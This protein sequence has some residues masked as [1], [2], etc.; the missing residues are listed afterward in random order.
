MD[1]ACKGKRLNPASKSH[2][3]AEKKGKEIRR[4]QQEGG[5]EMRKDR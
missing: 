3:G 2:K 5:K 4:K 1:W